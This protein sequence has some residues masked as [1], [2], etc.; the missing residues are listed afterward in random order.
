M[1]RRL[2]HRL[3]EMIILYTV[4]TVAGGCVHGGGRTRYYVL[5][6]TLDSGEAS[7]PGLV[8]P[9]VG[10]GPIRL[11]G[12]LD[13]PQIAMHN[14]RDEVVLS[15]FDE[16][17]EPLRDNLARTI[18]ENLS[19]LI[20]TERV[21]IFPWPAPRD[22]QYQVLIDVIRFDRGAS[23]TVV[24]VARW[25]IADPAARELAVRTSRLSET[26]RDPGPA[27]TVAAMSGAAGALSREIAAEIRRLC[28]GG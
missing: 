27:A 18:A 28:E 19:R 7:G 4:I 20:P 9:A 15:E 16:W 11:P 24:L 17:A 12:Y 21:A 6:P 2:R 26:A 23:G 14:G 25:R 8:E 5:A 3:C 13:R 1:T 22:I 10:V